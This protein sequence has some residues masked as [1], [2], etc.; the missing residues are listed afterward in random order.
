MRQEAMTV[1]FTP[2]HGCSGVEEHRSV[3][4]KGT[5]QDHEELQEAKRLT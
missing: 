3:T 1:V 4:T 5:D 2:P